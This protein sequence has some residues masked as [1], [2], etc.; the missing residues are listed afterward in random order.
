MKCKWCRV[1]F[2]ED[3]AVCPQCGAPN[4]VRKK[5]VMLTEVEFDRIVSEA[6]LLVHAPVTMTTSTGT[7]DDY[8][9][10]VI[11]CPYCGLG[12]RVYSDSNTPWHCADCGHL[13][14]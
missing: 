12:N 6:R 1:R 14:T 8:R 4:E 11:E 3:V 10:E 5:N 9:S 2:L 13:L 7:S